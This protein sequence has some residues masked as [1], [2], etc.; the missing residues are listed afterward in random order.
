M[1]LLKM[2]GVSF[3]KKNPFN[4][5]VKTETDILSTTFFRID[6]VSG[7]HLGFLRASSPSPC[8]SRCG[9]PKIFNGGCSME[10]S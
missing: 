7:H 1:I 6:H 3:P 8:S 9:F 4:K 10:F 2:A 5:I